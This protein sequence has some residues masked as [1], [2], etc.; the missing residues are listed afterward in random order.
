[1]Q[2]SSYVPKLV[3]KGIPLLLSRLFDISDVKSK[4]K[5]WAI[6]PGG[7]KILEYSEKAIGLQSESLIHSYDTLRMYG[8]LVITDDSFCFKGHFR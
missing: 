7:K 8:E 2:L 4:V 5:H 1:M 6:H 3:D